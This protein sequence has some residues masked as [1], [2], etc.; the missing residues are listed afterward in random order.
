MKRI[1]LVKTSLILLLFFPF[2]S[3]AQVQTFTIDEAIQ[4]AI[5]NNRDIKI[6]LMNVQKADAAV[7][8][9]FGY[10]LPK[11]DASASFSHFL[12]KPKMSFPDF[13]A[14]LTNAAYNI[15]FDENVIP[16]DDSKFRPVNNTLQSFVQANNFETNLQ[17]TQTLFSSAVFKGIG[18]SHIY[19]NLAKE[20][21][22]NKVSETVL[23]VQ[24]TFYG[25][26]LTKELLKITEESFKNAQDNLVTVKAMYDQGLV[27]EF[28]KL[29]AEVQVENIR[30]VVSQM[31]NNLLNAKNA[32]KIV[33]GI[34]QQVDIDVAGEFSF[35]K[36][37]NLEEED[38]VH[39]AVQSNYGVK[40]LMLKEQVD[41]AFVDLDR[42][43]FWPTLAA[44]GNYTYAGTSDKWNFQN[45]SSLTVGLNLSINLFSGGQ[46]KS[47]I[48]QSTIT[49]MQT[50][51]Q[52]NQFKDLI[53]SQIKAKLLEIK[54]V[55]ALLD[56]QERNVQLAQRSY[57]IAVVKYKEGTATQIEVQNT[58]LALKQAKINKLQSLHSYMITKF[59]LEQL[60][61][62]TNEKY[63][64]TF[65]NSED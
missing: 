25:V 17:L 10:A 60:L 45:Y 43:E 48:E 27:A 38:L 62:Q 2:I 57:E 64:G 37:Q 5:E 26:L 8:E 44:F 19:L 58:D 40:T 36:M 61:G 1:K 49:Y 31:Q 50:Q 20:D 63:I 12:K 42:A 56:A 28:D 6:A 13:E 23:N 55:T 22:K 65:R 41:E 4:T 29:Q 54:R 46:T 3:I 11:L 9:A 7:S 18:A 33:I 51:E 16:R 24:E 35:D 59:E 47:R 34:D 53:E 14:L 52:L 30:P 32:L 21:L 39:K 15:L